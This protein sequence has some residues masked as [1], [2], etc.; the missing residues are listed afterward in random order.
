MA[1]EGGRQKQSFV[2]HPRLIWNHPGELG[3]FLWHPCRWQTSKYQF[4]LR[5][6]SSRRTSAR[7]HNKIHTNVLSQESGRNVRYAQPNTAGI[8]D[9]SYQLHSQNALCLCDAN[10]FFFSLFKAMWFSDA[11]ASARKWISPA[12][13]LSVASTVSA[14]CWAV[15]C[16]QKHI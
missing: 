6:E 12:E 3:G 15:S 4:P 7:L 9:S 13:S 2:S 11:P 16:G 14:T 5:G 10:C 8:T 1:R